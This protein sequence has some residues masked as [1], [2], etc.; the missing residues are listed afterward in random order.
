MVLKSALDYEQ[1]QKV[2]YLVIHGTDGGATKKTGT[3]TLTV[4]VT[5]AND[6]APV[7]TSPSSKTIN[8]NVG[9]GYTVMTVTT[10]DT[11]TGTNGDVEYAFDTATTTFGINSATGVIT[12]LVDPDR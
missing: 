10:N 5:D 7:F 11:D 2:Y 12:T 6:N 4:S 8:E 3:M 9:T 1:P